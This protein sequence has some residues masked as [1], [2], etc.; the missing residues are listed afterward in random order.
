M[1]RIRP[2]HL[3]PLW[4]H[5]HAMLRD[6]HQIVCQWQEATQVDPALL[7]FC[8]RGPWWDVLEET[9]QTLIISR[10]YEHLV[11]ALSVADSRPRISYL[12]LPHP[13]GLAVDPQRG[14]LFVTSTRNPNMVLEFAPC[15]RLW[16]ESPTLTL[17]HKGGGK[18][19][20]LPHK[21]GGRINSGL[22]LP[23]C[24]LYLPGC[25]YL[26]DLAWINGELYASAVGLNAVVRLPEA[27]GFEPVW[28][29]RCIDSR[30]GPRFER[31]YLQLNSIAAGPTLAESFFSASTDKPS[32]RRPGHLNFAV[33]GRGVIFSGA[34]RE[35]FGRGLTRPHSARLHQCHLWAANSGYGEVGRTVDG[36]FEAVAR[37]PGWTRGLYFRKGLVFAGTSHVIPR[38]RHYA[39]GLDPAKCE[40]AVHALDLKSGRVLA[41]L[42]WPN[43]NQIFGIEGME[44]SATLGFPFSYPEARQGKRHT[45][46]FSRGL[47]GPVAC[48]LAGDHI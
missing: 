25:L 11:L 28:W 33:D 3:E 30:E 39:P 36:R 35:V 19:R 17:P 37:L 21:G 34:T 40:T 5:H 6:P 7:R 24:S 27:G 18:E 43:G 14:A 47:T 23:V 45:V 41:S 10:E 4:Q 29:P 8:T 15:Q 38:F 32:R 48:G 22:L 46:F 44:R 12:H 42:V 26:H 13:N 31:N 2:S 20:M 1:N 16:D 9:G